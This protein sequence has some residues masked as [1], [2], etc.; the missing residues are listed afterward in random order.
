M[1]RLKDKF[2]LNITNIMFWISS[3]FI[4]MCVAGAIVLGVSGK[5]KNNNYLFSEKSDMHLFEKLLEEKKVPFKVIS[6]T[7]ISIPADWSDLGDKVYQDY[8]K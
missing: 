6:D 7:A 4:V 1:K 5:M 8:F 2:H 3:T